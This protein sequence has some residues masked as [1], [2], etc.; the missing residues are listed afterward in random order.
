MNT[1]FQFVF[2]LSM[3]LLGCASIAKPNE[4]KVKHRSD[5][6]FIQDIGNNKSTLNT[7]E[8]NSVVPET[9]A[10]WVLHPT[11][12]LGQTVKENK[13]LQITSRNINNKEHRMISYTEPKSPVAIRIV[14]N[15]L[16]SKNKEP[17]GHCLI[18]SKTRF[19]KAYKDVYGHSV[20]EDLPGSIA[21]PYYTPKEVFDFLYF[22]ASGT[23]I[24]WQTLPIEYRGRGNA[25]AIAYAG[26]GALVDS[27]GI[28][29]GKLNPGAML[30]VW[31]YRLDY[32]MVV[33]GTSDKDFDPYGH[34]FIFMGYVRDEKN[35]IIGL[36]IAD[37]GFQS[38][39][40][41]NPNDYEVW[42]GV[43]LSI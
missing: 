7:N 6:K 24:G 3:V 4:E 43:N 27:L 30:Q 40:P 1:Q 28:W 33:N 11:D 8:G 23:H 35:K 42:W 20:Y 29:Q 39:R 19:E 25:G 10:Y 32:E 41:L 17:G 16:N 13:R 9:N 36:R 26:M 18:V 15:Y 5:H 38:Y 14:E 2:L 22:S 21:T 31:R 12:T 34:S 37:Q